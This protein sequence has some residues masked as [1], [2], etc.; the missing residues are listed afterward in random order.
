MGYIA[1]TLEPELQRHL[2]R[3]KSVLLLGPRQTGKTTL[4][5]RT[6][7]DLRVSLVAPGDRQRYE[8]DPQRLVAE[9]GA[10]PRRRADLPLVIIDEVQRVPPLLDLVQHAIDSRLARFVLCGSSAR[11]LRRGGSVNL[12][13]GRV[14]SLRLDPFTLEEHAP[15]SLDD[16]LLYGSL[17]AVALEPSRQD[18]DADL[19]TYVETYLEEEIRAEAVVRNVGAFARFLELAGLES[20]NLVSFRAISQDLGVSHTTVADYFQILVDCL[21]AERV[22]PIFESASRRKLVRSSRYLL[23]DLGV[24]RLCANEG[25]RLPRERM[26]QL[27][28]QAVGLELIRRARLER[29]PTRVRF[30]RDPDGPEVDWVVDRA[31]AYVPIE[32]KWHETPTARDA[33]HLEVFLKEYP[34]ASHGLIVCR[35]PRA[36]KISDRVRAI[37]W[38]ELSEAFSG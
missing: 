15:P 37:P 14:V 17:P 35:T 25:T 4:L 9:I 16:L 26:G 27:F 31:G 5:E 2:R 7:A 32:V 30:F 21:V 23:F 20:G 38:Q 8:Q 28:E 36:L 11:K 24:R 1:R 10:L 29:E 13:P 12:L 6:P 22:E 33:R 18:R 34:A 19:R 3:G